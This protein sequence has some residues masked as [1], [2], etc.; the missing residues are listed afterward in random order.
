M[1]SVTREQ[2]ITPILS[3]EIGESG[4][5][6]SPIELMNEVLRL[7][8][9][10]DFENSRLLRY[11][12]D[13]GETYTLLAG[14]RQ[15][16]LDWLE[17]AVN[18]CDIP[19]VGVPEEGDVMAV[20]C[21]VGVDEERYGTPESRASWNMPGG[22]HAMLVGDESTGRGLCASAECHGMAASEAN[23]LAFAPY[24]VPGAAACNLRAVEPYIDRM[25]IDMSDILIRPLGE[26]PVRPGEFRHGG[27]TVFRGR[28][29]NFGRLRDWIIESN[30]Q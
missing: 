9:F 15:Q 30:A 4:A 17:D 19:D 14:R 21:S 29:E 8:D 6:V 27:A 3:F 10:E 2:P 7:S 25:N 28:D 22:I 26:D 16:Y 12:P 5:D 11:H 20:P 24:E 13:K 1:G 23:Q 18:G